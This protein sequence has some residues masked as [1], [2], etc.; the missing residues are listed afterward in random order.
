MSNL[1]GSLR[2]SHQCSDGLVSNCTCIC[3][4]AVRLASFVGRLH[5]LLYFC[6]ISQTSEFGFCFSVLLLS[7]SSS[8]F[9][10]IIYE[11]G[12][13][14]CVWTAYEAFSVVCSFVLV[15]CCCGFPFLRFLQSSTSVWTVYQKFSVYSVL[16]MSHR[17]CYLAVRVGSFSLYFSFIFFFPPSK[18]YLI[19]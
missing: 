8:Q 10:S 17:S 16:F 14:T 7:F 19:Q 18:S 2:L 1:P 13:V 12:A 5:P 4:A 6:N 3:P 9:A 11:C 15:C